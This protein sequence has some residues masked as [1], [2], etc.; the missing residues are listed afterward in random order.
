MQSPSFF[1]PQEDE[2]SLIY[3]ETN[4]Q[5]DSLVLPPSD[6]TCISLINFSFIIH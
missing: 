5:Q 4:T 1:G 3:Y 2:N 6:L